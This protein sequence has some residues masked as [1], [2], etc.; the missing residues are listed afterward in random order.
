MLQPLS[1]GLCFKRPSVDT[2]F[3]MADVQGVY[4]RI[5]YRQ[6]TVLTKNR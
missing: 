2:E 6:T 4:E 5:D 1:S 3:D